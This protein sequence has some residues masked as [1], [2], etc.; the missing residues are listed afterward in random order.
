MLWIVK[1]G[2][3]KYFALSNKAI[4]RTTCL[5]SLQNLDLNKRL[6]VA[7]DAL[8][9]VNVLFFAK[10][11]GCIADE[12]YRYY[13]NADSI[14]QR[15][16]AQKLH[17]TLQN[18]RFVIGTLLAQ[19]KH[20]SPFCQNLAKIFCIELEISNINFAKRKLNKNAL[21]YLKTSFYKKFLRLQQKRYIAKL[22][23]KDKET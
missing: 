3:G 22:S 18:H 16:D 19:S 14:M 15:S 23:R 13:E 7:E 9:F 12:L 11:Y 6:L 20:F 2:I 4:L 21:N 8:N 1:R 5:K 17:L 10:N